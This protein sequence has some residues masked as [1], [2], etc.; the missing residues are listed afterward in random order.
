MEKSIG[1]N[2]G[3][4]ARFLIFYSLFP[5]PCFSPV[6]LCCLQLNVLQSSADKT[7][8]WHRNCATVLATRRFRAVMSHLIECKGGKAGKVGGGIYCFAELLNS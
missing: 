7:A 3:E 2:H 6:Q 5:T 8:Y 1:I 4:R